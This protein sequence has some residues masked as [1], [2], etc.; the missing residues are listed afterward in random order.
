MYIT[1]Y[2]FLIHTKS[3]KTL[4]SRPSALDSALEYRYGDS[5]VFIVIGAYTR[6]AVHIR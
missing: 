6:T 1:Q 5:I 4:N 3:N 2:I